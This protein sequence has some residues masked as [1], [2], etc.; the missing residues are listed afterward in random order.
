[1]DIFQE[2][3]INHIWGKAYEKG[4]FG[5]LQDNEKACSYYQMAKDA[6]ADDLSKRYMV[7]LEQTVKIR[8]YMSLSLS[9]LSCIASAICLASMFSAPAKSAIVLATFTIRS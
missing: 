6:W 4:K 3:I 5:R 7:W 2:Y 9:F 8:A 1:M